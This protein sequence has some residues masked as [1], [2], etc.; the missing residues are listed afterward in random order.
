MLCTP[1]GEW[2]HLNCIYY[3][4]NTVSEKSLSTIIKCPTVKTQSNSNICYVCN[5]PGAF[6]Q[7]RSPSCSQCFHFTCGRRNGCMITLSRFS[8]CPHHNPKHRSRTTPSFSGPNSIASSRMR[9]TNSTTQNRTIYRNASGM[10]TATNITNASGNMM[11]PSRPP[12]LET[13]SILPPNS[14]GLNGGQPHSGEVTYSDLAIHSELVTTQFNHCLIIKPPNPYE[15]IIIF[16]IPRKYPKD[17]YIRL[18]ALTVTHFGRVGRSP[19]MHSAN[20]LFPDQYRA[21]R[22]F[23]STCEIGQVG[24]DRLSNNYINY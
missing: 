19:Y 18:G 1:S 13:P 6:L 21:F 3:S 4:Q 17:A 11:S 9:T 23:W 2:V 10:A 5:K 15:L 24:F 12:T 8:Y 20:Y 14:G 16:L 22:I 7:C